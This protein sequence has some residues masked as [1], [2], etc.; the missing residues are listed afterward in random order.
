[1]ISSKDPK[2][3]KGPLC[4]QDMKIGN[5]VYQF[6]NSAQGLFFANK[7]LHLDVGNQGW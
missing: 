2:G 1:M 6:E 5:G 3:P 4:I 7:H